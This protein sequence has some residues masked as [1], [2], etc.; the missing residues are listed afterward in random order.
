MAPLP[1]HDDTAFQSL[2][3]SQ[4]QLLRMLN[5]EKGNDVLQEKPYASCYSNTDFSNDLIHNA[6]NVSIGEVSNRSEQVLCSRRT[7]IGIGSDIYILPD[8]EPNKIDSDFMPLGNGE[9]DQKTRKIDADDNTKRI[10]RRRS[11]LVFLQYLFDKQEDRPA[12]MDVVKQAEIMEAEAADVRPNGDYGDSDDDDY[13]VYTVDVYDDVLNQ[14]EFIEIDPA[15]CV[16]QQFVL[17]ESSMEKSQGSQQA[18]HDWDRK[19]G[20]KR[21]HS[22]TMRLSSRSRKKLRSIVKK[23]VSHMERHSSS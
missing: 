3:S 1:I 7:S 8:F 21:S 14:T 23:Q 15:E 6:T 16:R 18:I 13:G 2:L 9:G 20:L 19:M 17:F 10:K 12:S 5:L 11:T 22:K 4:R